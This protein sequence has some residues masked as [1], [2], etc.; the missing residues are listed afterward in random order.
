MFPGGIRVVVA[1]SLKNSK[2]F[3]STNKSFKSLYLR[4]QVRSS[5][6]KRYS[7]A[8]IDIDKS[9]ALNSKNGV[10]YA[11]RAYIKLSYGNYDK[12]DTCKDLY[13]AKELGNKDPVVEV[14]IQTYCEK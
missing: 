3:H 10:S 1:A 8:K 12:E 7:D 5:E 4:D 9:I 2:H 13:T 11:Y 6:S 14:F